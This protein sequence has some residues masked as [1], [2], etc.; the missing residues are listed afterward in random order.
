[1]L[2]VYSVRLK[3]KNK[4]KSSNE[5][6]GKG[7]NEKSGIGHFRNLGSCNN[8]SAAKNVRRKARSEGMAS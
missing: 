5:S 1:M 2:F 4:S 8:A 7:N 6:G 3:S